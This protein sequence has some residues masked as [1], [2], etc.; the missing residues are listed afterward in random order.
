MLVIIADG[1]A[2]K[3][4]VL[5]IG[6]QGIAAKKGVVEVDH[7]AIRHPV[8]RLEPRRTTARTYPATLKKESATTW[9][10]FSKPTQNASFIAWGFNFIR[11][12]VEGLTND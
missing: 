6:F 4:G 10:L 1:F 7:V 5:V 8:K 9:K 12:R 11:S 3:P 2:G